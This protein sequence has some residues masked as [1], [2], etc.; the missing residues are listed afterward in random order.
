MLLGVNVTTPFSLYWVTE[1]VFTLTV[2]EIVFPSPPFIVSVMGP[3]CMVNCS[4]VVNE[5][6]NETAWLIVLKTALVIKTLFG[7]CTI[8]CVVVPAQV[9]VFV[10]PYSIV[11]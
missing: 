9:A 11:S 2:S 3:N 8:Y 6:V 4:V 1:S 7:D 5:P 10:T